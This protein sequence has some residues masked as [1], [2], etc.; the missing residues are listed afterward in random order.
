MTFIS[1]S[2]ATVKTSLRLLY[3]SLQNSFKIF[4]KI[5][6]YGFNWFDLWFSFVFRIFLPFSL[7]LLFVQNCDTLD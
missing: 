2:V 3:K 4:I 7:T 6:L 1:V 5:E